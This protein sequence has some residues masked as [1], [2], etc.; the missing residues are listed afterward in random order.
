MHMVPSISSLTRCSSS[1]AAM[2]LGCLSVLVTWL[3]LTTISPSSQAAIA[4]FAPAVRASADTAAVRNFISGLLP[5]IL[6]SFTA[7]MRRGA[8]MVG[9]RG[10]PLKFLCSSPPFCPFLAQVQSLTRYLAHGGLARAAWLVRVSARGG[11]QLCGFPHS[12]P[13]GSAAIVLGANPVACQLVVE[14]LARQPERLCRL[15]GAPVL[16]PK[17][18]DQQRALDARHLLGEAQLGGVGTA[19]GHAQHEAHRRRHERAG[20]TRPV[21]R[22]QRGEVIGADF[23]HGEARL[24]GG[25]CDVVAK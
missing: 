5:W 11:V 24:L 19:V 9:E 21:L 7:P 14:G 2:P 23:R 22:H 18:R 4:V 25:L 6:W 10:A 20:I 17:R 12:L 3:N 13:P 16:P 8:H 15:R 1:E